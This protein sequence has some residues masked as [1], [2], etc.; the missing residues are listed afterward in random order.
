[1][2]QALRI[3]VNS[4]LEALEEGLEG[5]SCITRDGGAIVVISYHS[6]ED[7]IVKRTFLKW[8]GEYKGRILTRHPMTPTEEE[9]GENKSSRSAKLRAFEMGLRGDDSASKRRLGAGA[10]ANWPV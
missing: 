3:A 7:R 10:S 8:A 5:A 1:V 6:L 9:V 4:E 2:F